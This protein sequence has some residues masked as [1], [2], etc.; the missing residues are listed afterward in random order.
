MFLT[1][2]L[3]KSN[4]GGADHRGRQAAAGGSNRGGAIEAEQITEDVLARLREYLV[5]F[6]GVSQ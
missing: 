6:Q 5:R 4:R 3:R 1:I 2:Q